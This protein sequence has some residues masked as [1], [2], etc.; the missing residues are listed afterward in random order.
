MKLAMSLGINS[1]LRS[2]IMMSYEMTLLAL[3][4]TADKKWADALVALFMVHSIRPREREDKHIAMVLNAKF[5][6]MEL[7]VGAQDKGL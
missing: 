4:S 1:D 7:Y 3:T 6:H 5:C 2:A